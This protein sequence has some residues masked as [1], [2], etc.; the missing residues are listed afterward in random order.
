[1]KF[2]YEKKGNEETMF[3]SISS[4]S[5]NKR[6]FFNLLLL[7]IIFGLLL[8]GVSKRRTK[9]CLWSEGANFLPKAKKLRLTA[10]FHNA[11]GIKWIL[12]VFDICWSVVSFTTFITTTPTVIEIGKNIYVKAACHWLGDHMTPLGF[13][14]ILKHYAHQWKPHSTALIPRGYEKKATAKLQLFSISV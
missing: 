3:M 11:H 5:W 2:L 9:F 14:V 7:I 8:D 13:S 4:C 12:F 6:R 10:T 1:M